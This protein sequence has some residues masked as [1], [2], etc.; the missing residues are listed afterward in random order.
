MRRFLVLAIFSALIFTPF[1][2]VSQ[3]II[4]DHTVISEF[5]LI[6]EEFIVAAKAMF[7]IS[8]GHTSHGSQLITG[9]EVLESQ[10]GDP[11]TTDW[12]E[13]DVGTCDATRFICDRY[14]DLDLGQID[15]NNTTADDGTYSWDEKTVRLLTTNASYNRNLIMWSWCGQTSSFSQEQIADYLYDMNRLEQTYTNVKFVYMTGHRYNPDTSV[16]T[17]ENYR[18]RNQQIRNYVNANNKVLFDF[19]DIE[20]WTPNG[21][22]Y[23]Y[24]NTAQTDA[25]EWCTNYCS[26]QSGIGSCSVGTCDAL[27]Y[28]RHS[29]CFNCYQKGKAFWW[30]LAKLAGWP[31]PGGVDTTPPI[32]SGGSPS[33]TLIAGTTQT[34]ISLATTNENATCRY[35]TTQGVVYSSMPVNSFT[36]TG[37]RSHSTTVTGLTNGGNYSYYVRCIDGAGNANTND[38]PIQFSIALPDTTVPAAISNLSASCTTST[39]CSLSWRAPGDDGNTGTA[40]AYDLRYSLAT[41]SDANWDAAT[42]SGEPSPAAAGTTQTY[43]VTGLAPLTRYYFAIKAR[44]EILTHWS[45]LSNIANATT[46]EAPDTAAPVLSNGLPSGALAAGTLEADISVNTNEAATCRY[47]TTP[48]ISFANMSGNIF[49]TTGSS[50]HAK[51][52]TGLANGSTYNFYVKCSDSTGNISPDDLPITFSIEQPAADDDINPQVNKG[53]LYSISGGCGFAS[54]ATGQ[55][56]ILIVL[57]LTLLVILRPFMGNPRRM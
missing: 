14:P 3:P 43:T 25:C 9:F 27:Y 8:Y 39:S 44:D 42:L 38:Y 1:K 57:L 55:S 36:T 47:A 26:S 56:L 18:D 45:A 15:M 5:D 46:S 53:P 40:A 32:R 29:H 49:E 31:G 34:T 41:I 21:T 10:L 54:S 51:H 22:F 7:R 33:N 2:A 23:D 28:C 37:A 24:T 30:L 50:Y 13:A 6:P 11:Y 35:S 48:D 12:E 4:A 52:I 20:S 17:P 19:A 16:G